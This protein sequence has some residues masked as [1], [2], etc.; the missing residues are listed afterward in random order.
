AFFH[1]FHLVFFRSSVKTSGRHQDSPGDL[2]PCVHRSLPVYSQILSFN[3]T[4][5][6]CRLRSAHFF[7]IIKYKH[8]FSSQFTGFWSKAAVFTSS[9]HSSSF[10]LTL[11]SSFPQI[12]SSFSSRISYSSRVTSTFFFCPS[13]LSLITSR[14]IL[15]P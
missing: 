10:S 1:K 6:F 15:S 11:A 7:L 4:Y 12:L 2:S 8:R 3:K 5:M 14:L 9:S 13:T